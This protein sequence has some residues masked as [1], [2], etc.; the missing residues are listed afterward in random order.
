MIGIV[1]LNPIEGSLTHNTGGM[2]A[3]MKPYVKL[4]LD[5]FTLCNQPSLGDN[6]KWQSEPMVFQF[7]G[8]HGIQVQVWDRDT[9]SS[10]DCIGE[11]HIAVSE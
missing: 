2:F 8:Q 6:P 4:N 5:N 3:S 10:D 1:R 11:G 9:F 7:T